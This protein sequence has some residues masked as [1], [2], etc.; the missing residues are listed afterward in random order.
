MMLLNSSRTTVNRIGSIISKT[1]FIRLNSSE[2]RPLPPVQTPES[3]NILG[4]TYKT[5]EWTN[6]TPTILS[7][8]DRK[9]HKQPNHPLGILRN[10][11]ETKFEGM[12]YTYYNDFEPVVSTHENFDILGFPED[13]PG[14]SKTDTYYI[15]Q[16]TLLR[17]HTSA[18]EAECFK[19]CKT[20]GY[21]ITADVYR[22]D[23]IDRTHYPAFHQIEGARTWSRN[24]HG[25]N[26]V[27]VIR[28]DLEAL[29]KPNIVVENPSPV[30]HVDNPK[31]DNMSEVETELIAAHLKRTI[32]ILVED[33]FNRAKEVAIA[34]GSTDPDLHAPLKARWIEAYF[35]WTSPS[36]EIEVWWKGEWLEMCGCGIVKQNVLQNAGITDRIGWA[37]G[38]G[39]ERTAM[40]LFG[41]P[42]IRLFWSQ[43]ERFL[44]QFEAGK[45]N[46]FKPYSKYPGTVRDVAFWLPHVEKDGDLLHEND[47]TEMVRSIAGDLVE[48][49]SLHDEFVHPKT[50]KKSQCYR[51]NYQSMDRSLTNSEI[52]EYQDQVRQQLSEKYNVELLPRVFSSSLSQTR[53]IRPSLNTFNWSSTSTTVSQSRAGHQWAPRFKNVRK[54][55]KGRVPV[56]T[57]GS[58]KGSAVS[59]GEY[60]LRLKSDGARLAAI[61]L[62]EADNTIMRIIR[63]IAGP[64][65]FRM[66]HCNI[67]VA[68]KGNET[69]MG[70]GKGAFDFWACRVPTGKIVFEL[71]G[72][73]LH[74]RVAR[75][76]F[77]LASDKLPGVYEIVKRGDL[78]KIGFQQVAAPVKRNFIEEQMKTPSNKKLANIIKSKDPEILKYKK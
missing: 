51:I 27:E 74:E 54:Q 39:L 5:D 3:L 64:K 73:N 63:P 43:D 15:N 72:P 69:R 55:H 53:S 11:I 10:L 58:L 56:R 35:P 2:S 6:A 37:F 1:T 17:T 67:A 28:A 76:A 16:S 19:T 21:F 33:I 14:R 32:E 4:N 57:G 20:P 42:D 7:L 13:H 47:L 52:N 24:E 26:I 75:E 40:L 65:L 71:G 59:M 30:F 9:L 61:Q 45:I 48:N 70:K 49:V 77:R 18:H 8:T 78:P 36:W 34:A 60:G 66:V 23:A 62:K 25:N 29:P 12:G 31:Q 46:N 22:R 68:K 38:I 41:I 50:G 44:N